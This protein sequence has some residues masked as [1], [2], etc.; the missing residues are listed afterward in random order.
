MSENGINY[1]FKEVSVFFQE[2]NNK[3]DK[4]QEY[5]ANDFTEISRNIKNYHNTAKN[6]YENIQIILSLINDE[7]K[8]NYLKKL[9]N[10]IR[11]LLGI[12]ANIIGGFILL[13]E[14]LLSIK[15]K[16]DKNEKN[17]ASEDFIHFKDEL[18]TLV[19]GLD[20]Y[21]KEAKEILDITSK[22]VKQFIYLIIEDKNKAKKLIPLLKSKI[23]EYYNNLNKIIISIQ[24]HDIIR[25]KIEHISIANKEILTELSSFDFSNS[26]KQIIV[27]TKYVY[28]IPEILKLQS[29]ILD[30]TNQE[31][32]DAF[33]T[34][35]NNLSDVLNN[36]SELLNISTKLTDYQKTNNTHHILDIFEDLNRNIHSFGA[37]YDLM[38]NPLLIELIKH[39]LNITYDNIPKNLLTNLT[40]DIKDFTD[41]F[42]NTFESKTINYEL[43]DI[44][45]KLSEAHEKYLARNH[46]IEDILNHGSLL[47]KNLT[48]NVK[49]I[50]ERIN[51][52]VFFSDT[53]NE[54]I[55]NLSSF[56]EK[57][58]AEFT[59]IFRPNVQE[60]LNFLYSLYSMQSERE[61]H[62]K[63]FA[64]EDSNGQTQNALVEDEDDVE[65][66]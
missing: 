57:T 41:N 52:S 35:K 63:L 45:E 60:K 33:Y 56:Y 2:I 54:L 62:N 21:E 43:D 36:I 65:F 1:S 12:K 46:K 15:D 61:I 11:S 24:F 13:K 37:K 7:E 30:H 17:A 49:P 19:L 26:D 27:E 31:C 28:V 14:A 34:I 47:N 64:G 44:S 4:L 18:N 20:D 48:E 39:D 8:K 50:I 23:S 25:Q 10:S 53:I 51:K 59:D 16:V 9:P 42:R 22:K 3:L 5:S 29:A 32:Q 58:A 38:N 66:F 40:K 6:I 55:A